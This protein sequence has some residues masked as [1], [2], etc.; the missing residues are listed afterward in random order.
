MNNEDTLHC[1][2]CR[3]VETGKC[4]RRKE[5]EGEGEEQVTLRHGD[6]WLTIE[7]T[8]GCLADGWR[9][10]YF[11]FVSALLPFFFALSL[12]EKGEQALKKQM[13]IAPTS[14]SGG[15]HNNKNVVNI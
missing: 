4:S 15:T 1:S 2:L 12:K 8:E 13:E 9:S 10:F 3:T 6:V 7:T 5:G 14:V 11:S